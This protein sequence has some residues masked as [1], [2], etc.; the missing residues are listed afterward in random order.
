MGDAFLDRWSLAHFA[1]GAAA[2]KS[3]WVSPLQWLAVHTLYEIWENS[4]TGSVVKILL[5]HEKDT[6]ANFAGDT[7]SA[8]VGYYL[9]AE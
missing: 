9:V 3:G 5:K 4:E 8:M 7:L 6:L 2:G 1:W